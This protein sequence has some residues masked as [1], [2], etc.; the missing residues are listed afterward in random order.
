MNIGRPKFGSTIVPKVGFH[1][2][3]P[4]LQFGGSLQSTI[5]ASGNGGDLCEIKADDECV[6]CS[7]VLLS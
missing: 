1:E 4:S 2:H 6:V 5:K 3:K 7:A